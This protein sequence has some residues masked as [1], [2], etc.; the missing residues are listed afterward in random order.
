[1]STPP[2][3][4]DDT[5]EFDGGTNDSGFQLQDPSQAAA[6]G[7]G[8][9]PMGNPAELGG[10]VLGDFHLLRILGSGGMANVYLAEQISLKRK[11]ALK[12]LRPDLLAEAAWL[13]VLC[14]GSA[15]ALGEHCREAPPWG[16]RGPTGVG[17]A[18]P[19]SLSV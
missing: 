16:C 6:E 11:V 13:S 2:E 18:A 4:S 17:A 14:E 5:V 10:S 7:S 3:P 15:P 9:V 12:V 1:M 19:W 8:Q